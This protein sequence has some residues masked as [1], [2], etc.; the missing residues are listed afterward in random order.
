[1]T[2][3][4]CVNKFYECSTYAVKHV[5]RKN[6]DRVVELIKEVETLDNVVEIMEQLG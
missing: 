3:D 5:H 1:M 6:L 4:D 2:L